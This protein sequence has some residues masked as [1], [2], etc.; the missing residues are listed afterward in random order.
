MFI[1]MSTKSVTTQYIY[2]RINI[3]HCRETYFHVKTNRFLTFK[4][5]EYHQQET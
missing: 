5:V 3:V 2:Y 4:V 1:L